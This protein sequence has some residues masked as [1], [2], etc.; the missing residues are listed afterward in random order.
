[1]NYA[2]IL[3][4]GTSTRFGKKKMFEDIFGRTLLSRVLTLCE[5]T[6]EIDEVVVVYNPADE[7]T[8]IAHNELYLKKKWMVAKGGETRFLS[9]VS[10]VETLNRLRNITAEDRFV[11]LN[12]ANP[13]S[14]SDEIQR[15]LKACTGKIVGVAVGRSITHSI[16]KISKRQ[17][18]KGV[19]AI[20][21]HLD[22]SLLCETET[23]QVVSAIAYTKAANILTSVNAQGRTLTDELAV[24]QLVDGKTALVLAHEV[25]RKITTPLD[26]EMLNGL[27]A[28]VGVG[29]D[30][31]EF[32]ES[33]KPLKI[34]GQLIPSE[35]AFDADSDGDVVLHAIANA[36]SS[37]RG[38]DSLGTFA[39]AMCED[40][41]K[42]S[43]AYVKVVMKKNKEAGLKFEHISLSL[44]GAYPKIDDHAPY[45]RQSLSDLLAL[46]I[47]RIGIT[48]TTGKSHTAYGKGKALKCIAYLILRNA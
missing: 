9:S 10:A 20:T 34:A 27:V 46:P 3:A 45:M 40:G 4:A 32:I 5:N 2:V 30:S 23:P 8:V 25:N 43:R 33:E 6:P 1:M 7:I 37:A 18:K 28:S 13:L 31:H 16:K 47:E 21:K 17:N 24:L 26:L 41:I 35:F 42:D 22:R 48:A 44:E 36:I 12:G 38:G 29:E 19:F 11:F 14:T 39:S 15:C